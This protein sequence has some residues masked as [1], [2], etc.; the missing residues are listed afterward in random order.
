MAIKLAKRTVDAAQP[1]E[2]DVFLFDSD[3]TGFGLKVTPTGRK[4]YLVQYRIN[5][6]KRRVTIGVHGSPWTPEQARQ[7]AARL[8]GL[9]ANGKDPAEAKAMAKTIP[10]VAEV[11]ERFFTEHVNAKNKPSTFAEYRRQADKIII[12]QLGK[13]RID[14]IQRSHIAK[15]HHGMQ[16]TPYTANR[17]VALLSK[18]FNWCEMV[19]LRPD[20]TN[21]V[22][23][24]QKY[25]EEKRE[26]LLSDSELARLG[27]ALADAERSG[28]AS[29]YAVT[30]I[31]LIILTGAR[32]GEILSLR[33]DEVDF[34]HGALRL[35]DSKTATTTGTASG[36]K[37]IPLNPPALELLS[38]LPRIEGN[39]HVIVG[40]IE[41]H[42]MVNINKPWR[43]IR[44]NAGLETLRIHDLRHAFASVGASMGMSL[45]VI[46]KLLG[47]TQAA[48]TQRYAHLSDDPLQK[49]T[50]LIG[51]HIAAAMKGSE[52][53]N[54]IPLR[55]NQG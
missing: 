43:A 28:K 42:A 44:A 23:H 52:V 12:P 33:W 5:G 4:V 15:L 18:M 49:A 38:S 19:G 40:K 11:V 30:A 37:A 3:L 31:R 6:A 10:T 50:A 13:Y 17:V 51:E 46:G 55:S 39:P 22:L 1:G 25:R 47:H 8:L 29:P 41:G 21:P 2:Q 53:D 20:R 45:P 34:Q 9:V 54:I 27:Q 24:I 48:T 35:S 16:K 32:L 26:R 7:E 14:A 36:A